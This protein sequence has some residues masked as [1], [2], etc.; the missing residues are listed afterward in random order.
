[1]K[2]ELKTFEGTHEELKKLVNDFCSDKKTS[3]KNISIG[4]LE[5]GKFIAFVAYWVE[6]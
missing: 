1:M 2:L 3:V 4:E 6:V 5:N